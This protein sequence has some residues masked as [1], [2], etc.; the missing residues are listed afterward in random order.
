MLRLLKTL[1]LDK[2][3]IA[4][5]NEEGLA[6]TADLLDGIAIKTDVSKESEIRTL[7]EEVNKEN[8]MIYFVQMLVLEENLAFSIPLHKDGKVFGISMLCLIFT[9]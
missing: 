8:D 2:V 4:D 1:K 6:E 5:L 3:Y 9:H 7:I